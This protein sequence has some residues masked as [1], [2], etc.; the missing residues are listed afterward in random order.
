MTWALLPVIVIIIIVVVVFRSAMLN[1]PLWLARRCFVV[2][3]K[4]SKLPQR[5]RKRAVGKQ[6]RSKRQALQSA[7][8]QHFHRE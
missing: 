8:E 7:W 1:W 4:L 5:L 3:T 6:Q 2:A